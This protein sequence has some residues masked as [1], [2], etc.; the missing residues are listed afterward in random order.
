MIMH[1][2]LKIG[3]APAN[4]EIVSLKLIDAGVSKDIITFIGSSM[5]GMN[6]VLPI[7]IA[8]FVSGPKTLNVFL[9]TAIVRYIETINT[10]YS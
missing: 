10:N 7:I 4:T 2:L 1:C 5:S 6:I 8:K 3:F 9:H